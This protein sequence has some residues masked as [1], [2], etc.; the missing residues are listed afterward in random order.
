MTALRRR[1]VALI[2]TLLLAAGCA[3]PAPALP[4]DGTPAARRLPA[5]G[6]ATPAAAAG[7]PVSGAATRP[8]TSLPSDPIGPGDGAIARPVPTRP[9]LLTIPDPGAGIA[10]RGPRPLPRCRYTDQPAI[11]DPATDWATIVLDTIFRLPTDYVPERLVSTSRTGMQS[12]YEVIPEVLD[13]LEALHQ[14]SI[15]ADA[16]VAVRWAYRSYAE[17]E[18]VFAMWSAEA[19]RERALRI[20][21]RPGHSEHQ[22]GTALDFR[23]ADSLTAPWDY[24]DWG[25]TD[26]GAWM[27]EN[28]WRYGF[29]LS[30]PFGLEEETC[31]DYEPWH[32]RYVGREIAAA[33]H[34]SGVSPRRYL[35][36]TYAAVADLGGR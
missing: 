7:T 21:A 15:R 18:G 16:E 8:P 17:Q 31:Y 32:F 35:W 33:I 2:A 12:G 5:G 29:V 26:P 30:F 23:S 27:R 6:V 25:K 36:E 20:S 14:A 28:S 9:P 4:E 34:A 19:G 24:A 11:G 1:P 22:L 10:A 13:D 3:T